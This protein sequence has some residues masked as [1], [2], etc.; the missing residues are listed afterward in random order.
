M[1]SEVKIQPQPSKG[2]SN[3][4]DGARIGVVGI[5]SK[6]A[7]RPNIRIKAKIWIKQKCFLPKYAVQLLVPLVGS[8][9]SSFSLYI[10]Y[11]IK[12]YSGTQ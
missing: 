8:F 9:S 7:N 3:T 6:Q 11:G 2:G 10:A 12:E 1:I 4:S 5:P